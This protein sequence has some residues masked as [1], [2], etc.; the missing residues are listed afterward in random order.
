M[1][2]IRSGDSRKGPRRRIFAGVMGK[3]VAIVVSVLL[4]LVCSVVSDCT[5]AC[6]V[7]RSGDVHTVL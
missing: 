3:G 1:P 7:T 4:L 2:D 5:G 6:Q